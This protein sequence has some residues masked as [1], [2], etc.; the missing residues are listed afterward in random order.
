MSYSNNVQCFSIGY[1]TKQRYIEKSLCQ[2]ENNT[3]MSSVNNLGDVLSY[4]GMFVIFA[5]M[6]IFVYTYISTYI[7]ILYIV[8]E[9]N[10]EL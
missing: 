3:T 8:K 4:K 10:N 2:A 1:N 6:Y 9:Y 5:Y 7:Y